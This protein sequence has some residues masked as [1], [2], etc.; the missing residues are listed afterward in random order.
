MPIEEQIR[1]EMKKAAG[2][3]EV[4]RDLDERIRSSIQGMTR[5]AKLAGT[6]GNKRRLVAGVIAA[7]LLIPTGVFAGS[8]LAD[9]I[10]GSME[11]VQKHGGSAA[12]YEKLEAKLQQAK[13]VLGEQEYSE[14]ADKLQRFAELQ[15][16][17]TDTEGV[18]HP[19]RLQGEEKRQY[20]Q[21]M[22]E[23]APYFEK[24][25]QT[26]SVEEELEKLTLEEAK[27]RVSFPF[28]H[29]RYVPEGYVLQRGEGSVWKGVENQAPAITL[30]YQ[31]GSASIL[32]T[33]VQLDSDS[34][35]SM[36]QAYSKETEYT[37]DGYVA[38]YGEEGKNGRNG[39]QITVPRRGEQSAYAV[40]AFGP[41]EKGELEKIALS[42]V[43]EKE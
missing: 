21:V 36:P 28:R 20:E 4:P 12:E 40:Y 26:A 14:F 16:R 11:N 31:K 29:P 1:P 42:V 35:P 43:K 34:K 17:I 8:Y 24:L 18:V 33:Y 27:K 22:Q 6:V 25:N 13:E 15:L 41:I 23:L 3:M 10:F 2:S 39:L 7:T 32:V 9:Q 19:E 5:P 37:L 38:Q 30:E